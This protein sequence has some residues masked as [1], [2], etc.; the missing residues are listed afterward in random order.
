MTCARRSMWQRK[1]TW[2]GL[3][4]LIIIA[5]LASCAG[6]RTLMMTAPAVPKSAPASPSLEGISRAQWEATD[7]AKAKTALLNEV[8]GHSPA[9]SP[10]RF[11][12]TRL[13]N[14]A[15]FNG[16]ARIEEFTLQIK[17]PG[18]TPLG[19][20][21]VLA[22][23]AN[24]TGPVP[25][26]IMQNFCPNPAVI[27]IDGL[28]APKPPYFDCSDESALS[29]VFSYFFGRYITSPP[30][31]MIMDRG[32]ALA[33][34]HPPEWVADSRERSVFAIEKLQSKTGKPSPGTIKIWADLSSALIDT[35]ETDARFSAEISYGHSRYG[36]SAL[37]AAAFDPRIDG[38]ISHQ[39]GTGG[40]SLSKDKPGETV[41]AITKTYPHWFTSNYNENALSV[42][43]HHL[44]ALIAPRPVMLGNAARDVWSDPEGAFRAAKGANPIYRAYGSGGLSAEKLTDF[45]P[46]DDIAFWMRPGT[47]GV[48]QEDWP[49][50]LD[51]MDAHFKG[52]EAKQ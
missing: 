36:K 27:P 12:Q 23:P 13:V 28:T 52:A 45:R 21:V 9:Y 6:T 44:I 47:H 1:R 32:Y 4:C 25:V 11:S 50:F 31:E 17:T 43:Q 7:K 26:I 19:G 14:P 5:L 29:S 37:V 39:S 8:Y 48:T 3:L 10:P 20:S 30:V 24:A 46:G 49:A 38:V 51:F 2:L 33:V 41:Q 42:D 35:L 16:K 34:M 40:A 22:V 18:G 15:A